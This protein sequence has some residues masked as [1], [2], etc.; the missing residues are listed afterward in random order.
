M[1]EHVC[2]ERINMISREYPLCQ[3]S[4][5]GR[6]GRMKIKMIRDLGVNHDVE[7]KVSVEPVEAKLRR[8]NHRER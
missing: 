4:T 5:C 3:C 7:Y 2:F 1:S 6:P 8:L